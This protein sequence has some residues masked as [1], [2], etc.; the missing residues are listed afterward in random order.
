MVNFYDTRIGRYF[1]AFKNRRLFD[2][3]MPGD[4]AVDCGANVGKITRQMACPGV[5]VYAFEPDPNAFKALLRN[6]GGLSNVVCINK[7][8]SDHD[9]AAK[10]YFNNVY[11]ENPEKWST[12]ST[13]L[14]DKPNVDL[15]NF[16]NVE[17]V[18][19]ARFI[20]SLDR[21]IAILKMDIEGE[22]VK[23]LNKLIDTGLAEKIGYIAV[24]THERFPSLAEATKALRAR[25]RALKLR[26]IDLDWA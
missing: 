11:D 13:L 9:G 3:L 4:V 10:I 19:L 12:G 24:E 2:S 21:P 8:V 15:N 5:K 26:N 18:D 16:A 17:V 7:A 14:A 25:I 1:R 6:V 22:E 20:K 23:V